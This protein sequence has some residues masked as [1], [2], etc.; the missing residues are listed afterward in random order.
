MPAYTHLFFK[1]HYYTTTT[2]TTTS[3]RVCPYCVDTNYIYVECIGI[4]KRLGREKTKKKD[5]MY[6]YLSIKVSFLFEQGLYIYTQ[7]QTITNKKRTKIKI[8][9]KTK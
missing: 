7:K 6:P 5:K 9:I 2:T 1:S 4:C 3:Y 8:E